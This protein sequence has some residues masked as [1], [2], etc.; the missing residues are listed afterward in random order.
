MSIAVISSLYRCQPHL[1]TFSAALFGFARRISESGIPAHY[2]PIVNDASGSER[3]QIELLAGE[4]NSHYYGRMT[5][6]HV[7]RESLY[8]SWNRGIALSQARFFAPWNADDIRS[9]DAFIEGYRALQNGA[10]LVDFRY[11]RLERSRRF[12]LF[13]RETGRVMPA[14]FRI[15]A[16]GRGQGLSPFFMAG[17]ALYDRVGGFD[18]AFLIAGDTEWAARARSLAS[19]HAARAI[20]G[21]FIVHGGNL[22]NSGSDREDIEVNIIFMRRGQWAQLRPAHPDALREAWISWGNRAGRSLPHAVAD[23]LWGPAA[24]RRWQRYRRERRQGPLRRKLRLALAARGMISSAEWD[25]N[26]RQQAMDQDG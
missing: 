3:E 11:R 20:G 1:P 4:I 2:L 19:Y 21:D 17:R 10:D 13:Q 8:A 24:K 14:R 6:V 5:P 7:A 23:Y 22:S 15:D 25:E 18:E 26:L 9:A 12:R 16:F